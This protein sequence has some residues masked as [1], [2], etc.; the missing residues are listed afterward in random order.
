MPMLLLVGE[1][2]VAMGPLISRVVGLL[3]LFEQVVGLFTSTLASW[4]VGESPQWLTPAGMG[5]V[6]FPSWHTLELSSLAL[7]SVQVV[8]PGHQ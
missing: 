2:L 8:P 1:M 3:G 4:V 6:L 7:A 5:V